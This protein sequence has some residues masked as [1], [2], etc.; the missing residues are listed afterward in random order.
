MAV[1]RDAPGGDPAAA[2]APRVLIIVPAPSA[3]ANREK[4]DRINRIPQD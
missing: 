2:F 4:L 3:A 1:S